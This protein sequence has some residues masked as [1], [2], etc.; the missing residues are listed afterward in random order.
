MLETWNLTLDLW[1]ENKDRNRIK[2]QSTHTK[3]SYL[4]GSPKLRLYPDSRVAAVFYYDSLEK[5]SYGSSCF[6]IFIFLISIGLIGICT[7]QFSSY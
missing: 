4:H 5:E 6:F 1:I 7:P 2:D 3:S